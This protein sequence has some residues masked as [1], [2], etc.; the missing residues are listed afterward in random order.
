MDYEEQER[1]G[2]TRNVYLF[3]LPVAI[4]GLKFRQCWESYKFPWTKLNDIA[5][6]LK[7]ST[8]LST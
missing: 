6:Y 3:K 2:Y 1:K 5:R 8:A 7:L 4:I